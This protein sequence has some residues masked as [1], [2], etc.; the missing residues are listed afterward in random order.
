[1]S[2]YNAKSKNKTKRASPAVTAAAG[3]LLALPLTAAGGWIAYSALGIDHNLPL[4]TA[5]AAERL[6]ISGENTGRLNVYVDRQGSMR[7]LVLVHSI[8]AAAS[9]YEMRPL[10]EH[11]RG[12]RP[13]WALELPGFGFSER[14]DRVYAPQ[15]YQE[16]IL[17]LLTN[18][19]E[20]PAD[21]V[22]LSLGCEFIASAA[23]ARP[24]LFHSLV[25][26]SPTGFTRRED[27]RSSQRASQMGLSDA[28][29]R[30]LSFPLW[31]QALYDLI[32]TRRSIQFFLQQSFVGPVN[33]DLA[34]YGYLTGH[35]SGARFAPL[36]FLSGQLFT[37]DIRQQVYARLSLPVL[38]LYDRDAFVGFDAL[39]DF[40][41]RRTNWEAVRIAPSQGLPHFERLDETALALNSFWASL[42]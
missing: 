32:V 11:Y 12:S 36:Y 38:V 19:V 15:L 14:A 29:Y 5:I 23:L 16:A 8:N 10:F 27:G 30:F 13:I 6:P 37:P 17:E 31:A 2:I 41:K 25:F 39:P 1:M 42:G 35:Q 7:P 34:D 3:T 18:H 24:E 20:Q 28:T 4:P 33:Q 26:I 40:V 9:A 21:V 22:A